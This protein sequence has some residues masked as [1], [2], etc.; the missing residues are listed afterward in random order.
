LPDPTTDSKSISQPYRC[1][2]KPYTGSGPVEY[3]VERARST[4]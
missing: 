2:A 4:R 3:L 1:Y